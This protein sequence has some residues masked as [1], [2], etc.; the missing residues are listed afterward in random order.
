MYKCEEFFVKNNSL[1]LLVSEWKPDSITAE[2]LTIKKVN[3]REQP[4]SNS[5]V[6]KKI[7]SGIK[8]EILKKENTNWYKVKLDNIIGYMK[9][10]LLKQNR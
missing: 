7:K 1:H 3:L 6:L 9:G 5:K 4:N 2:I 10:D 8:I